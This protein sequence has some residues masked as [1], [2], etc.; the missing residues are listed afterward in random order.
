MLKQ[1]QSA[2]NQ[3]TKP[4]DSASRAKDTTKR[5]TSLNSNDSEKTIYHRSIIPDYTG[6]GVENG[7]TGNASL[8]Q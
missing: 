4:H 6:M 5:H 7:G 1:T 3:L 8:C 2:V